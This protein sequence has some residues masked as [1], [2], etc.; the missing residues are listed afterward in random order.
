V[1]ATKL[2]AL[3][4]ATDI[5]TTGAFPVTV[6]TPATGG[7]VSNAQTLTVLNAV[8]NI[9]VFLQGPFAAGSM[10]TTLRTNGLIPLAHPYG[11]APWSYAGTEA[12]GAIP[13]NVVDWILIEL[14][15]GTTG[16]TKVATRAAFLKSDGTVVDLDGVSPVTFGG[17]VAGNYYIVVRH[18]NHLAVMSAASVPVSASSSLYDFTTAQTQAFGTSPL[19]LLSAGVFGMYAGDVT[20]NGTVKYSGSGN[21]SGPIYSRIGGASVSA[22]VAGYFPE[23]TNMNGIVKYSGAQ[24]ER[25]IIYVNIGGSSVSVTRSTQVP[26]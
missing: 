1:S 14:R 11:G 21:D 7:G 24:N 20:A 23:D 5:D 16:A 18:R 15:T 2:T 26:L 6:F 4:P 12:V 17:I 19:A 8:V 25:A 9:K 3:I 13:A 10:A 22:T